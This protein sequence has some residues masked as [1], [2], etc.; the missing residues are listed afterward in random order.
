MKSDT[1]RVCI[2]C[3]CQ[4]GEKTDDVYTCSMCGGVSRKIKHVPEYRVGIEITHCVRC[5]DT[6][7][8]KKLHVHHIDGNHSNNAILNRIVLC[9]LVIGIKQ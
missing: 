4:I 1:V 5:N 6:G 3:G 2:A 8:D 7:K 9:L